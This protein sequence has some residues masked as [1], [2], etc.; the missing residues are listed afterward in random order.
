MLV[1]AA[2]RGAVLKAAELRSQFWIHGAFL[3]LS[4]PNA[5]F[6]SYVKGNATVARRA[7]L[8]SPE[9]AQNHRTVRF[10]FRS[11]K[12]SSQQLQNNTS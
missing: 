8:L 4:H 5:L 2:P 9:G 11:S 7:A 10:E 6:F 3:R 1:I 12:N